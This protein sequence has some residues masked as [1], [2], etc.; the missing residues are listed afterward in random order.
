MR[1]LDDKYDMTH[2]PNAPTAVR[3]NQCPESKANFCSRILWWWVTGFVLE[4][5][6]QTYKDDDIWDLDESHRCGYVHRRFEKEWN[7]EIDRKHRRK[8]NY[9]DIDETLTMN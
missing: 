1:A 9:V 7:N 2:F 6:R 4:G 8:S 5:F 3:E